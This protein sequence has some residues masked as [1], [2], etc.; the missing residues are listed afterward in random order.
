MKNRFFRLDGTTL[1]V[2]SIIV[3][4]G[5]AGTAPAQLPR[6]FGMELPKEWQ[7]ESGGVPYADLYAIADTATMRSLVEQA[8]ENNPNLQQSALRVKQADVNTELADA[9]RKPA[10][11]ANLDARR[12]NANGQSDRSQTALMT[13]TWEIDVWGRL[14]S[15][16]S[17]ADLS[18]IATES[19]L[20]AARNSLAGRVMQRLLDIETTTKLIDVE[21][22]RV[23]TLT[24]NEQLIRDR[25][26]VGL[27]N[28]SDLDA[29]RSA[30]ARSRA[31]LR[32]R[33]ETLAQIHRALAELLGGE[34]LESTSQSEP[35]FV[36]EALAPIPAVVVTERPDV[37]AAL[38]RIAA[39]DT[40]AD[41][42]RAALYPS[43][44]L[45]ADTNSTARS[46]AD[47]FREDPSWSVLGRLTAPLFQ[48]GRL[49]TEAKSAAYAAESA[50]W[51]YREVLLRALTEV[52]DRLGQEAALRERQQHLA[53]ALQYARQTRQTFEQQYRE[54]LADI[55][56]LLSAQQTAYD[57]ES[58]LLEIQL[59]RQRNRID[60]GL[61]LGLG[62]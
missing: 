12:Q 47:A 6:A 30:L 8:L 40:A 15:A 59:E 41:S 1:V 55:L 24:V 13:L 17:S 49:R 36:R 10:L 4:N 39:A 28:L 34:G 23:K 57:Q 46:L 16:A 11:N 14:S 58:Q 51:S 62:V 60:L 45:T 9:P 50:Y 35:L 31:T 25:Y 3:L 54:G 43:F 42:A 56:D 21:Q 32:A 5:C 20:Q 19:D 7:V 52:E 48:G 26:L 33:E 38:Y 61:A 18:L 29:A 2:A 53:T 44:M 22:R 27:G 37:R